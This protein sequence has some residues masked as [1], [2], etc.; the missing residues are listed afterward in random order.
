MSVRVSITEVRAE[1][2]PV[3]RRIWRMGG[4]RRVRWRSCDVDILID[5]GE[6]FVELSVV[7]RCGRGGVGSSE[8]ADCGK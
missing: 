5:R 8:T 2:K 1:W 6:Q 3:A 4:R 7:R